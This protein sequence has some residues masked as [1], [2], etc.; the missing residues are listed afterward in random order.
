MTPAKPKKQK[1][2]NNNGG[3]NSFAAVPSGPNGASSG[4]P[5]AALGLIAK[6]GKGGVAVVTVGIASRASRVGLLPGDVIKAVDGTIV[7]NI[8]D[9][10]NLLSRKQPGAPVQMTVQRGKNLGQV[11]L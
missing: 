5:M 1:H 2:D 11:S 8:N 6:S 3:G 9:L 7:S 10:N 4:D